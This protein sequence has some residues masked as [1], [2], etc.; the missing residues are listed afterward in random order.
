VLDREST[1]ADVKI[2]AMLKE[3]FIP[4]AID[5][6]YT[7]RQQDAEG[8]F[9]RQIA[10][11]GPRN[12]FN[13]TTQ[14]LYI[15][16]PAGKL[17]AYNNNRGPERIRKLMEQALTSYSAPECEAIEEKRVDSKFDPQLPSG[18]MVVR[19]GT[20]VME[21]YEKANDPWRLIFQRSVG[22][23]NLWILKNEIDAIE[24]NEMPLSLARRIARFH[25]VDNTRGQPSSWKLS[26]IRELEMAVK[27]GHVSGLV[28]LE[29]EDQSRGYQVA[30]NG[31]IRFTDGQLTQFNVV[32]EGKYWGTSPF[33]LEPPKGKFPLVVAF[34]LPESK[35]IADSLVPSGARG[36]VDG[37]LYPER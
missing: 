26:E 17:I 32:A 1:F 22:R 37:Y 34:Q 5:Q 2:I 8:D 10:G 15:A 25:L 35:D 13:K 31:E 9:Y 28:R 16:D 29:A 20:K 3:D 33:T 14:G 30:L 19:C 27:E 7:R 21:G 18:A 23:D 36:W 11:Q 24:K 4:V 6:W 12:D